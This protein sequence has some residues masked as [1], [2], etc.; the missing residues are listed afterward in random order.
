MALKELNLE[1]LKDLDLGR[2][3]MMFMA[4]LAQ[5]V[6]DC[7]NRPADERAR[8]VTLELTLKPVCETIGQT[9]SCEGAR[10]VFICRSKI[11]HWETP[12][13]D[14]GIKESGQLYFAEG[15]PRDHRQST[16]DFDGADAASQAE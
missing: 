9:L 4:A 16:L 3:N 7:I 14:F 15:S 2:A 6:R 5:A 10:G 13:V 8:K 1:N 11:P 12:E